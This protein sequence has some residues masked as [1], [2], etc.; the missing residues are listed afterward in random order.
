M[1][2]KFKIIKCSELVQQTL[3]FG[4]AINAAPL[5]KYTHTKNTIEK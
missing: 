3:T 1:Y 2:L 4:L 5:N